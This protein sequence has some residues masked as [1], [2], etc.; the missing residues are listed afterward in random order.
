MTKTELEA[1]IIEY[2][3]IID[4]MQD[5]VFFCED[6]E[7]ILRRWMPPRRPRID[8]ATSTTGGE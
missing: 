3:R 2:R 6:D 8:N 4:A 5:R 7:G 1:A